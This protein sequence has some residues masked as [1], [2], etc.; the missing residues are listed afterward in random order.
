MRIDKRL[1][2]ALQHG[3]MACKSEDAIGESLTIPCHEKPQSEH[4]KHATGK[5]QYA[6]FRGHGLRED[7]EDNAESP[8]PEMRKHVGHGVKDD[9]RRSLLRTYIRRNGHD[10]IRLSAH[11]SARSGVIER[12]TRHGKLIDMG[13]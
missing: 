13:K 8:K 6:Q 9:R 12:K 7:K 4:T 10:T 1:R 3:D 5:E 11:H 2:P